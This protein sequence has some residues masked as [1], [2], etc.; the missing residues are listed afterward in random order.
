MNDAAAEGHGMVLPDK[1]SEYVRLIAFGLLLLTLLFFACVFFTAGK[2]EKDLSA[3][4]ASSLSASGYSIQGVDADGRSITLRGTIDSGTDRAKLQSVALSVNGVRDV[5]DLLVETDRSP[6][7]VTEQRPST[8]AT[9][10]VPDA[11]SASGTEEPVEI[12][13]QPSESTTQVEIGEGE[14]VQV[15]LGEGVEVDEP[16][17]AV[18]APADD[19][20]L[21]S[22]HLRFSK[23]DG[24]III[25]GALPDQDSL[26]LVTNAIAD[27]YQGVEPQF[28]LSV[29][30]GLR[31]PEWLPGFVSL[32][33]ELGRLELF[34]SVVSDGEFLVT[35]L[36]RSEQDRE[37][38]L[39]KA[40]SA[41]GDLVD[42]DSEIRVGSASQ[43]AAGGASAQRIA[44][45]FVMPARTRLS[46][47]N[48]RYEQWY[49]A[50]VREASVEELG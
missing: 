29:E 34:D 50:L 43:A 47:N 7:A 15:E 6:G 27:A 23:V 36:A 28:D 48:V 40:L 31:S 39:S 17:V 49:A 13:L 33:P 11:D 38:F 10:Q 20:E 24:K 4:V 21:G 8:Q 44:S 12:T 19:S 16:S 14:E 37:A 41:L 46:R 26:D 32:V 5:V 45:T 3:R 9:L 35:G 2:V 30:A 25:S 1:H 18:A 22:A 42:V